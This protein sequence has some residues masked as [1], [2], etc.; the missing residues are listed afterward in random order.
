MYGTDQI[1]QS[2]PHIKE[3][4]RLDARMEQADQLRDSGNRNAAIE[5]YKEISRLQ[6]D[7]HGLS[8]QANMR[9]KELGSFPF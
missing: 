2:S 6:T 3:G 5:I 1:N 4:D 9:L 7:I 8:T